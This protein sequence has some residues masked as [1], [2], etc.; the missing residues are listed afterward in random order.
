MPTGA[1][2]TYFTA[3]Q[4]SK[5]STPFLRVDAQVLLVDAAVKG[6]NKYLDHQDET[7]P[8]QNEATRNGMLSTFVQFYETS[9]A[10]EFNDPAVQRRVLSSLVGMVVRVLRQPRPDLAI[11]ILQRLLKMDVREDPSLPDYSEAVRGLSYLAVTESQKLATYLPNQLFDLYDELESTIQHM[12]ATR[13]YDEA[14]RLGF[15]AFLFIIILKAKDLDEPTRMTKLREMMQESTT[16][17]TNQEFTESAK[18]FESFLTI[19]GLGP[20]PEYLYSHNFHK[21]QDW[22][23]SFLDAEGTSIQANVNDR[24]EV[25]DYFLVCENCTD[26]PSTFLIALPEPS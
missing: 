5:K 10:M 22:G 3:Q 1:I 8:Q 2:L 26:S 15:N 13:N 14:H 19:L 17:W 11:L 6:Y 21:I 23:D 18:G 25:N 4:F 20:L 12:H 16:V 7:D 24:M 9:L